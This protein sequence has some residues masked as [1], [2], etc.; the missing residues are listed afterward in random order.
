MY[1]C[2][3]RK[4]WQDVAQ[5]TSDIVDH[6]TFEDLAARVDVRCRALEYAI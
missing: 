2:V 1:Q 3:F 6:V 4:I 5:A